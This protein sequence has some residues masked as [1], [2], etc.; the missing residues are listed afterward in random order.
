MSEMEKVERHGHVFNF[1]GDPFE[2]F[3]RRFRKTAY[4]R[5]L[6]ARVIAGPKADILEL[7]RIESFYPLP[8]KRKG[9]GRGKG[10]GKGNV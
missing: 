9:K 3:E 4:G 1:N 8:R 7:K 10:K 6:L 2:E 5:H